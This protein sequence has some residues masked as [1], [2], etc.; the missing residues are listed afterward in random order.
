MSKQDHIFGRI[1]ATNDKIACQYGLEFIKL[2]LV[3]REPEK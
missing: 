3:F 1:K 2:H